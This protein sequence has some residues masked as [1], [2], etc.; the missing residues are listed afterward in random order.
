MQ[1]SN[2][3]NGDGQQMAN[4]INFLKAGRWDLKGSDVQAFMAVNQW[5]QG[6]A[7]GM[8]QQ[9]QPVKAAA[10]ASAPALTPA[11]TNVAPAGGFKVKAMGP[12]GSS[13]PSRKKK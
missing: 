8:A 11:P 4:L 6:L 13:K 3:T 5:V 2:V 9:L 7:M 12:I 1:V 10:P